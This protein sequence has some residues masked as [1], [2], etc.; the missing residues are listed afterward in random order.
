MIRKK[1]QPF[2]KKYCTIDII[3]GGT[4]QRRFFPSSRRAW[5]KKGPHKLCRNILETGCEGSL[6]CNGGIRAG[7]GT[8]SGLPAWELTPGGM[9]SNFFNKQITESEV[10][11]N[12]LNFQCNTTSTTVQKKL[13]CEEYIKSGMM[14]K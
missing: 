4:L 2:Q 14:G 1:K 9:G 7:S 3:I 10:G 13:Y 11:K 12:T 6:F 5:L 8:I